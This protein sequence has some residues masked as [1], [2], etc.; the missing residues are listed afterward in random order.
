MCKYLP[1]DEPDVGGPCPVS[2]YCP[3]GTG[4]PLACPA[5]TYNNITRQAVCTPCEAGYFC[6]EN[7]HHLRRFPLSSWVLLPEWNWVRE[8]VN[9]IRIDVSRWEFES[10]FLRCLRVYVNFNWFTD[11]MINTH[12]PRDTTGMRHKVW[13]W[14]I[15]TRVPEASIVNTRAYFNQLDTV[16]KVKLTV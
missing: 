15:V 10:V 7:H 2:H 16:M 4:Y 13:V 14:M 8:V 11:I 5:G 9:I 12:A 1:G 6:N 3:A